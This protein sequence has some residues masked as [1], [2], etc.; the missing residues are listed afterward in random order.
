VL[1]AQYNASKAAI[2]SLSETMRL[3]LAPLNVRVVTLMAGGTKSN[4]AANCPPPPSLPSTSRY[5]PI[6][7]LIA[8][9]PQWPQMPTDEFAESVVG[10]VLRGITG[11]MWYGE[12]KGLVRWIFPI[13]P[14]WMLVSN[15]W[16]V[17]VSKF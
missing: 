15:Y 5:L 6:E 7:S 12:P 8:K 9:S 14:Q 10:D 17:P 2:T 1:T 4:M 3:E 13:M 16:C 11:K